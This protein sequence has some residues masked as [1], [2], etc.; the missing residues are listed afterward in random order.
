[1]KRGMRRQWVAV[2]SLA[3]L[4]SGCA[5]APPAGAPDTASE[6]AAA[7]AL[8][9]PSSV[10]PPVQGLVAPP[11]APAPAADMVT[12]APLDDAVQH[13]ADELFSPE[14]TG[15]VAAPGGRSVAIDPLVDGQSGIRTGGTQ[16]IE[17]KL[18]ALLAQ[19]YKGF[20]HVPF[21]AA[22][23]KGKPLVL[24]GTLTAVNAAGDPALRNDIYRVCLALLDP[25]ADKVIAKGL[26]Y[27]TEASVDAAP[28]PFD[29]D[30]PTLIKD[31]P[32]A[33]Y[34]A[35]CQE[36]RAGSRIPASYL[37]QLSVAAVIREAHEAYDARH[38]SIAY[39]L[40][41]EADRARHGTQLRTLNGL[42]LS[43]WR[44]GRRS[45]A[46]QVF[47]RI[48]NRGLE[49]KKLGVKF[50]FRPGAAEL[51]PSPFFAEQYPIWLREIAR[52]VKQSKACLQVVGHT[53]R[54]GPA[55]LNEALSQRRAAY[56]ESRLEREAA[57]LGRQLSALGV[58]YSQNLV[59][60][61][62]DDAR[63]LI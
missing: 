35:A 53:S 1:M 32:V 49:E 60:T 39:R 5:A 8:P 58:G 57:G 30:S 59:G 24:V 61:G 28:T 15:P 37:D 50:L 41:S 45:E 38:Y 4:L 23:L 33:G 63:D 3:V 7:P 21:N 26:G 34:I 9:P 6:P 18:S 29:A 13:A 12:T 52:Q 56:V 16:S 44:L 10:A 31:A 40:Y 36:S 2:C 47:G 17:R 22:A 20:K 14:Q 55:P 25:S 46:A 54:S 42:Y 27:A 48:V 51:S 19:R 11:S 43:S 62:T